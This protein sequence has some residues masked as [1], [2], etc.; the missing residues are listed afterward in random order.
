MFNRA[1]EFIDGKKVYV[2]GALVAIRGVVVFCV[3]GNLLA[4]IDS[5]IAAAGIVAGRSTLD[6]VISST[7][8][9]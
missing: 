6:K 5:F 7:A 1:W 2:V 3:D 8:K 4:M 9:K